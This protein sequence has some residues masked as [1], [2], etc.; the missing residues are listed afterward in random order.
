MVWVD[1]RNRSPAFGTV[2]RLME[3]GGSSVK[4]LGHLS[5]R[6]SRHC[7]LPALLEIGVYRDHLGIQ[8]F[9][10]HSVIGFHT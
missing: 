5:L 10:E 2:P 7:C 1:D 9:T 4:L 6:P 3:F 8:V